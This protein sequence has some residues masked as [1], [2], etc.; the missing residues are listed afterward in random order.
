MNIDKINNYLFAPFVLAKEE[1]SLCFTTKASL[2]ENCILE[3]IGHLF[4]AFIL[5]I[6]FVNYAFY[7]VVV[8][9]TIKEQNATRVNSENLSPLA[10]ESQTLEI[11]NAYQSYPEP[12]APPAVPNR[13]VETEN[14][15]REI[16]QEVPHNDCLSILNNVSAYFSFVEPEGRQTCN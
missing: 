4:A 11:A 6:P 14:L 3:R 9:A 16:L 8:N 12:S 10:N 13:L 1:L 7:D 15:V 2:I 5:A